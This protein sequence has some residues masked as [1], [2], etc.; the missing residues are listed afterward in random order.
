[1]N[2]LDNNVLSIDQLNASFTIVEDIIENLDDLTLNQI[3]EG[4]GNDIDNLLDSFVEEAQHLV[5]GYENI[6]SSYSY[7]D[8]LSDQVEECFRLNSLNYFIQSVLPD[9]E[10]DWFHF[11]WGNYV[12]LYQYLCIIA[13]RYH[14]FDSETNVRMYDGTLKKIRDICVGDKVMGRDSTPRNVTSIH[15]GVDDMYKIHQHR[16][17]SYIVSSKHKLVYLERKRKYVNGSP[18]SYFDEVSM[19]AEDFHKK[20]K[21]GKSI[22]YGIRYGYELPEVDI[23]LEPYYLGLWLGDGNSNVQD[24]T[25]FDTEVIN[26]LKEYAYRLDCRLSKSGK[27]SYKIARKNGSFQENPIMKYLRSYGLINSKHIP[28]EYLINSKK[29]R[30]DLLAG[31]ID[32]DGTFK[33][34]GFIISQKNE[35]LIDEIIELCRSLGFRAIKRHYNKFI[36]SIGR[37]YDVYSVYISGNISEIPTKIPRKKA[38]DTLNRANRQHSGISKT[39]YLGKGRFY[40]FECDGDHMFLLE[41]G[42]LV[43]NSKSYFFSKAYILWRLYRYRNDTKLRNVRYEFKLSREGLLITNESK[44]A[45]DLLAKVKDEIE[46]NDILRER[47]YPGSSD[48][49]QKEEIICKNKARLIIRSYKSRMRGL[50]PGWVVLDDFLDESA[51]YSAE[52]RDKFLN[53]FNGVVDNL[54]S[55]RDPITIVG[56]PFHS[57][58]LYNQLKKSKLWKVFE[59]PAIFP[60]GKILWSSQHNIK[61]LVGK[62]ERQGPLIFSREILCKPVSDDSAIFTRSI[63]NTMIS[64]ME[65]Y[66]L[67]ENIYS[68]PI[69]F[70]KVVVGC[71]FA[72]SASVGADYSCFIT[73]GVDQYDTMYVLN[74]F[75]DKGLTYNQQLNQLRKIHQNFKPDIMYLEDNQMQSLFVDGGRE[76][77]LP[78]EGDTTTTNKKSLYEGLPAL[79]VLAEIGKIKLPRGDQRSKD[80]TDIICNELMSIAFDSDK[81]KLESTD[82]HDDTSMALWKACRA[83]K[84][85][86]K[87][88]DFSF[89]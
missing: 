85:A 60:D 42:T 11:E 20:T 43:H 46:V 89:L 64:N 75:R 13:A 69:K 31:L 23:N 1:M 34:N 76:L 58:D 65:N 3:L 35:K 73:L 86:K 5:L 79:A 6:N 52:Q 12:Q 72:R 81:G 8:G 53:I 61:S 10:L 70:K 27:N 33:E 62:R 38:F 87:H 54:V 84:D 66:R 2:F 78:I 16:A 7:I 37:N 14:C 28:K 24:I 25:N 29:V 45:R 36:K 63:I 56:T 50:H 88:F 22:C 82:Q 9:F 4:C 51:L 17:D 48:N 39:E 44:L 47:L 77:G 26:Y 19:N 15:S 59:Y 32:S 57:D 18:K 40:G 80:L 55:P 71:D 21:Y 49:W 30:L 68:F 83:A 41:D 67:V 74:M